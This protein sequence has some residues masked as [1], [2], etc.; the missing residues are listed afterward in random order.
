M[1][2]LLKPILTDVRKK[3]SFVQNSAWMFASSGTSIAVQFVFFYILARIYSPAVYGLF[4]V[5]NVYVSTLGNAATLGY[6][7][8]FVLPQTNRHFSSLLQLTIR[9][10]FFICLICFLVSLLFGKKIVGLFGHEELGNWTYFIAPVSFLLAMDR[11]TADW[12]IRNK[13]FKMQTLVSVGTT[14]AT[15]VYNVLHGML[16]APLVS[17]LIYTTILQ[18]L[19][20]IFTYMSFV[21]SDTK[22]RLTEKIT[23]RELLD[24]A[25][26]YKGYPIF[27]H[28]GNVI[29]IFS[30]NLPAAL[31]PLIGFGLTEAGYYVNSVV[32]L[33]IPIRMLGAGIASVYMQKAAEIQRERAHELKEQTWKVFKYILIISCIFSFLVILFGEKMYTL[34]FSET[35]STAGKAAEIL[36]IFYF[37]RM[38]SSPLSSLFNILRNEKASFWFQ[39]VLLVVRIVSLVAG[40][41]YSNDFITVILWYSVANAVM[42]FIYCVWIFYLIKFPL[43]KMVTV[44]LLSAIASLAGAFLIK[45]V[46][47][48]F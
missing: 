41:F 26:E 19:L 24:T 23:R 3:G 6:N 47:E 40:S 43:T 7:Q 48:L 25:R 35:W 10:S 22:E 45:F 2:K 28:W 38:I 16:I 42:Y 11:I 37:F 44:T 46:S 34:V 1:K 15:K 39:V 12:A 31:L 27:V 33:D 8:A 5:F 14:L 17:G 32:L 29:N 20:R 21:I 30:N 13:E 4:G 36:V 18:H 9:V